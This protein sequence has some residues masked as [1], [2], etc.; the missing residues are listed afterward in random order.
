MNQDCRQAIDGEEEINT[1]SQLVTP[2][3]IFGDDKCIF[4][5]I[6]KSNLPLVF[7]KSIRNESF[8]LYL[9]HNFYGIFNQLSNSEQHFLIFLF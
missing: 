9:S 6:A 5:K 3:I 1:M 4:S 8:I 7:Y 2:T